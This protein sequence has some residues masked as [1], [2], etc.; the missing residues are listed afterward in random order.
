MPHNQLAGPAL[1]SAI[2]QE[3][4]ISIPRSEG[5]KTFKTVALVGNARKSPRSLPFFVRTFREASLGRF[6]RLR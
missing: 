3:S 6:V 4:E 5:I 1:G 2:Q